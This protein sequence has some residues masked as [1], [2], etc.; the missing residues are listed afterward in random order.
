MPLQKGSV[1]RDLPMQDPAYAFNRVV[2]NAFR[3]AVTVATGWYPAH[4]YAVDAPP[5]TAPDLYQLTFQ[6]ELGPEVPALAPCVPAVHGQG[7][8]SRLPMLRFLLN[9]R[10]PVYAYSMFADLEVDEIT[11]KSGVTDATHIVAWNQFGQLD[12]SKPF[13]PFGPQPTTNSYL[14]VGSYDAAAM[15][16][17]RVEL[18]VEWG[19]LPDTVGGFR[20]Y[21]RGYETVFG[22]E[23]FQAELSL[24]RDGRWYPAEDEPPM[25][26]ALFGTTPEGSR[27]AKKKGI[28]IDVLR[29]FRRIDPALPEE[30]FRYD[31]K[32]RSGFFRVALTAPPAGFG[33]RDYPTLLTNVL[34]GNAASSRWPRRDP[35]TL[36]NPPYTPVINRI[37]MNYEA[38]SSIRPGSGNGADPYGERIYHLHP[39]STGLRR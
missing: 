6:L 8:N 20:E 37:S 16:L 24:L 17:T 22:N 18:V 15:N 21:Y 3:I 29:Y 10:A 38:S 34:S 12:T 19:D 32:A 25:T 27:P 11:I 30:Q 33:H 9:P 1:K 2:E 31:Q 35:Q 4:N 13:Q 39:V 26:T 23:G 5:G 36:P 28:K 14:I 7:Y